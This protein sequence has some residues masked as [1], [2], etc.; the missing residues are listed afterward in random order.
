MIAG[1]LG[2]ALEAAGFT[3]SGYTIGNPFDEIQIASTELTDDRAARAVAS[4]IAADVLPADM[5]ATF[6]TEI[7][8]IETLVGQGSAS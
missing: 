3:I 1:A 8:K 4:E 6:A 5:T 2:R 7:E